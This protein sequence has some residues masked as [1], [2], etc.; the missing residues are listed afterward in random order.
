MH[1]VL[2]D[3]LLDVLVATALAGAVC[4]FLPRKLFELTGVEFGQSLAICILG[5]FLYALTFPTIIDRSLSVYILEKIAQRGG[6]V[7][8]SAMDEILVKEF[9]PEHR[10]VDIRLTE[11]VNSGTVTIDDGCVRLTSRGQAIARFTRFYRTHIL[12]KNREIM[13]K[14]SDDLTDPFRRSTVI[15]PYECK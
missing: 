13:G 11:A 9:F 8:Q 6:A 5:G 3:T 4:F 12:P 2:Y 15:V 1:V 14:L 7:R 10:L